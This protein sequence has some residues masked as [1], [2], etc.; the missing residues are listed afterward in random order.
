MTVWLAARIFV[1]MLRAQDLDIAGQLVLVSMQCTW[2]TISTI[3]CHTPLDIRKIFHWDETAKEE[4]DLFEFSSCEDYET[5][6]MRFTAQCGP[7]DS[8]FMDL[9][10]NTVPW[11]QKGQT[12]PECTEGRKRGC[13]PSWIENGSAPP[14]IKSYKHLKKYYEGKLKYEET[15]IDSIWKYQ[16]EIKQRKK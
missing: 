6:R 16:E 9:A 10:Y 1:K 8:F 11:Q 7:I 4:V 2:P 15:E 12:M 3:D 14:F 13:L 5:Y